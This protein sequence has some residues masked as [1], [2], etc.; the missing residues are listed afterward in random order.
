MSVELLRIKQAYPLGMK[1]CLT[2]KAIREFVDVYGID[3]VYVPY[4]GGKDSTVLLHIIQSMYGNQIPAV[5]SNTKNEFDSIIKQV[6][7]MKSEYGNLEIVMSEK[8]IEDVI[9][10]HGYPVVSK[11]TSR[12]LRD[13][14]NPTEKNKATVNLYKTGV[15]ADG[16]KSRFKLAKKYQYLIEAPFKISEKC[17]DELKKKPFKEYEKITGR[18]P[19]IATMAHESQFRRDSYIKHGCNNFDKG[20]STPMGFWLEQD[21]LKYIVI[22]KLKIASVYGEIIK[23][24]AKYKLTGE[25]RTGCVACILGMEFERNQD[26]NRIQRLKDIEPKKYDYVVNKLGFKDVLDYMNYRY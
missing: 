7:Y 20:A 2:K 3:G 21:V 8:N 6:N 17:C 10:E 25:Q 4:S 24:G 16:T 9:K 11:K 26:K 15:K 19:I 5:F 13:I 22:N 14:K 12:M 1:V 18:K 23:A